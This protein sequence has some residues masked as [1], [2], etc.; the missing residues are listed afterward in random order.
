MGWREVLE[1]PSLQRVFK[2]R[3]YKEGT[4]EH[5]AK[6]VYDFCK[7]LG[8]DR[9]VDAIEKI[10]E[11]D[12]KEIVELFKNYFIE[13]KQT[14]APK[15]IWNY[16]GDIKIWLYENGVDTD[17]ISKKI[18]REYRRYVSSRGIPRL[19]KREHIER[20]EIKRI[21]LV[22]DVR[23]RALVSLLA[24]SGLRI[25]VSAL[26]LQ[27][28]HFRDNLEDDLPCYMLEIPEELT[29]AE[30]GHENPHFTFISREA[31]DYL[32]AYLKKREQFG[33]RIGPETY[34][35][36]SQRNRRPDPD[37]PLTY[38][39]ALHLWE[40][41]CEAAG[42][43]RKPV[44]LPSR[45]GRLKNRNDHGQVIR[46]NIR[47]HSLRKY[48]KTACSL[49]G[50]DRM[51]TE[52]MMGHS[53]TQFGIESVYDY[54]VTRLDWLRKEYLKALPALTFVAE[55]PPQVPTINHGAR[56]KIEELEAELQARDQVIN[57]LSE[58]LMEVEKQLRGW[59]ETF[60]QILAASGG[61]FMVDQRGRLIVKK[62]AMTLKEWDKEVKQKT[63]KK[64]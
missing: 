50:V 25:G 44:F 4:A 2:V 29:K 34:L 45:R 35:F 26:K 51:A 59:R 31:R 14:M 47:I 55:L 1:D 43:D 24:S 23:T 54:C 18:T 37:Q 60:N 42:I 10:R 57:K 41:A 33:E 53:L 21:I 52:A 40:R 16:M 7:F 63:K 58:R 22:S 64:K 48:F 28:K 30:Y 61:L 19:L 27:L 46:Y 20:D 39:G 32:M 5:I 56:K 36:V 62:K 11:M 8:F 13:R 9:P 17:P 38:R 3:G 12:L 6:G 49:M 15:T